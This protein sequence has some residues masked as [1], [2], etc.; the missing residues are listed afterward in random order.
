[1][2]R[3]LVLQLVSIPLLGKLVLQ[4]PYY[5]YTGRKAVRPWFHKPETYFYP[6]GHATANLGSVQKIR[7]ELTAIGA[8]YLV[9]DPLEGYAEKEAAAKLFNE[10]LRSYPVQPELAF[11][12][13]DG[14][15]RVYSLPLTDAMRH[16]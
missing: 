9:I 15:H 2:N 7:D 11:T 10:L 16:D 6:Y 5:L 4:L 1:M 13:A 12:S 3:Q 8:R 14:L